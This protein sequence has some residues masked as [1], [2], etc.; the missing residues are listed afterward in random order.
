M[1]HAIHSSGAAF[2]IGTEIS[3]AQHLSYQCPDKRFYPFPKNLICPNMKATSLTDVYH[4][5]S[6]TGGE[7]ISWMRNDPQSP[8]VHRPDDR[9]GVTR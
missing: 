7:V 4:A 1:E 8:G 3:I 5:V 9:M 6:G 2:I